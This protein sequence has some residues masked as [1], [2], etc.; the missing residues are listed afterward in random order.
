[1]EIVQWTA[2]M[3]YYMQ[4]TMLVKSRGEYETKI[5]ILLASSFPIQC[6]GSDILKIK[7]KEPSYAWELEQ[8]LF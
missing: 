8:K 3:I 5:R 4:G 1:M 6:R 7:N 2:L